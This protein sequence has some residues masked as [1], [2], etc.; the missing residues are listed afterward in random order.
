MKGK[1][2]KDDLR[3]SRSAGDLMIWDPLKKTEIERKKDKQ[4]FNDDKKI[5]QKEQGRKGVDN[6]V[7]KIVEDPIPKMKRKD[8][9]R[10]S[11]KAGDLIIWQ[12]DKMSHFK[13][14]DIPK[15]RRIDKV[16]SKDTPKI[17]DTPRKRDTPPC[18]DNISKI[19]DTPGNAD[20]HKRS[21][22]TR[23]DYKSKYNGIDKNKDKEIS[24][25]PKPRIPKRNVVPSLLRQ[26][27]KDDIDQ[28]EP[29][30]TGRTPK[31]KS[32]AFQVLD[33]LLK[34]QEKDPQ[35]K[36]K[37]KEDLRSSKRAGDLFIWDPDKKQLQKDGSK[38]KS[39]Q[40]NKKFTDDIFP[41][42]LSSLYVKRYS[43][44]KN[45]KWLRCESLRNENKEEENLQWTVYRKPTSPD[46]IMQ[47]TLG[48]CW[49]LSALAVLAYR[50]DL[51]E[52]I[53]VTKSFCPQGAY[54]VRLCK[55][56]YWKIILID[57]LFPCDQ[58]DRL[59]YSKGK[60][61]QLWVPLIEKAAAKLHG[62]YE[63]LTSGRTIEALSLLTGEPCERLDLH[64]R[65]HSTCKFVHVVLENDDGSPINKAEKERIWKK[66]LHARSSGYFDSVDICK[67]RKNWQ[68]L[69][70]KG[71]FPPHA[72]QR[73]KF[74]KLGIIS[75]TQVDIGLFQKSMRYALN[76]MLE[77]TEDGFGFKRVIKHSR[78]A[79]RSFVGCEVDLKP[80][81]YTIACLAFKHWHTTVGVSQDDR[82]MMNRD[83]IL[84]IHS[85][86]M[87]FTDEI[88]TQMMPGFNHLLAD[89]VIQLCLDKGKAEELQPGLV[90]YSLSLGGG[91][92]MIENTSIDKF[93]RV[94]C[95]YS[96][97]SYLIANRGDY[98]TKD[99]VPP[100]H[101][102]IIAVLSPLDST[103]GWSSQRL[104]SY[105]LHPKRGLQREWAP[106]GVEHV[107]EITDEL[108]GLY[109]P[110]QINS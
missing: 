97:S 45:P 80:G 109:S 101:R 91:I 14:D 4:H 76:Y 59:L 48:N 73:W 60:R 37:P 6:F 15:T 21:N 5:F 86:M 104:I 29:S 105:V 13:G 67:A 33:Q 72:A 94:K 100:G 36:P 99:C 102:Q 68:E 70:L 38:Q 42:E 7:L 64:G 74:Y 78:R 23:I 62:C 17:K 58:Y 63:A 55:D 26:T 93:A 43:Y 90:Q 46:D 34:V 41:P 87:V 96:K 103:M 106:A 79:L 19:L 84:T 16:L 47:G 1:N 69:R 50:E 3:S 75:D 108:A 28:P 92:F 25:I 51:L 12:P 81:K 22:Q 110:R 11:R 88:D 85:S 107:P 89:C 71:T 27:S 32:K 95:D 65:N 31:S 35:P 20:I 52:K 57:D 83:F 49:Y 9:L 53:I 10:S 61:R 40:E 44:Q 82:D 8:D 56:G 30:Q 18:T 66:L 39:E 54:M 77:D 24:F 2:R 98:L